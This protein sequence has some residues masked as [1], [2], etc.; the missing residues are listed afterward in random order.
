MEVDSVVYNTV[1]AACVSAEQLDQVRAGEFDEW[2]GW[3]QNLEQ[4][5]LVATH[6]RLFRQRLSVFKR[7]LSPTL[8][9]SGKATSRMVAERHFL[10]RGVCLVREWM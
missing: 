10:M 7:R 4:I 8:G 9:D 6:T 3:L 2:R 1:L 5:G